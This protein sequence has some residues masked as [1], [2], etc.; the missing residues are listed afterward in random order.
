[1][2]R[3]SEAKNLYETHLTIDTHEVDF[4]PTQMVTISLF[5]NKSYHNCVQTV[6]KHCDSCVVPSL[7]LPKTQRDQHRWAPTTNTMCVC[8]AVMVNGHV[9]RCACWGTHVH[10]CAC[11]R[12]HALLL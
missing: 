3:V 9:W 5:E 10:V 8:V 4:T 2:L 6:S 7:W 11:A 1:M 12:L